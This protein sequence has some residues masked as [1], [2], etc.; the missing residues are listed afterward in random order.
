MRRGREAAIVT[1]RLGLSLTSRYARREAMEAKAACVRAVKLP[2]PKLE[3]P[4]DG[5]PHHPFGP[6]RRPGHQFRDYSA[7]RSGCC[8][9]LSETEPD[10][11]LAF[12]R[13]ASL[14]PIVLT[15]GPIGGSQAAKPVS[16][17]N[18]KEFCIQAA[19][20][21]LNCDRSGNPSFSTV[22]VDCSPPPQ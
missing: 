19:S 22:S 11:N 17:L 15:V 14:Q 21:L 3:R 4:N 9:E 6:S 12:A 2:L 1:A 5:A 16:P 10:E 18:P 8:V 7:S 13:G 20:R